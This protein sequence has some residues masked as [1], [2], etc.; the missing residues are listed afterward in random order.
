MA[1]SDTH[2]RHEY[3]KIPECDIL[4]HCGD[5]SGMGY[6][7]EV[8]KFYKWLNEQPAKYKISIQGNHELYFE[9]NPEE[10]KKIALENC[11]GVYLL[12][13][14]SVIIEGINIYGT[15]WTPYFFN[16]A[17]N[18]A[19][20]ESEAALYNIPLL[21]PIMDKIPEDTDI[22]LTHGPPWGI[23]DEIVSPSGAPSG[24]FVGCQDL[25]NRVKIVKPDLHFFGHIHC[26]YGNKRQYGID[27][28]N[29]CICD[30]NYQPN[31]PITIVEYEK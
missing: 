1:I 14:E 18:G 2:N 31:N 28:Y 9:K 8:I 5:Y 16:W 25:Y 26:G 4:L 19:R 17:Y 22:L 12:D 30:E 11:P 23:L 15:P 10:M 27:F 21:K 24:R 3:V 6:K 29:V 13:N 20:N 7:H